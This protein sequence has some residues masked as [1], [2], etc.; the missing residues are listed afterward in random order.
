METVSKIRKTKT[1][2]DSLREKYNISVPAPKPERQSPTTVF[3]YA[4]LKHPEHAHNLEKLANVWTKFEEISPSW[5]QTILL[6][7]KNDITDTKLWK[8][9]ETVS[10]NMKSYDRCVVGE[11]HGW[12]DTYRRKS[13]CGD[14]NGLGSL[15]T[16]AYLYRA[17]D[18]TTSYEQRLEQDMNTPRIGPPIIEL[19]PAFVEH[20]DTHKK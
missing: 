5:S 19:I 4:A 9:A 6:M 7:F 14:C 1:L 11:A 15:L 13:I 20:F 2:F 10:M 12:S 3:S 17:N 8:Y 16:Y 18:E